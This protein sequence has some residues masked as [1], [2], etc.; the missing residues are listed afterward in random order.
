MSAGLT[1]PALSRMELYGMRLPALFGRVPKVLHTPF[2]TDGRPVYLL[3][4]PKAAGSSLKRMLHCPKGR[5]L[6]IWATGAFSRRIWRDSFVITAVRDP[7]DRFWSGYRFHVRGPYAGA[8]Y[9]RHGPALKS[10]SPED[11]FTFIQQYPEYLGPQ[12]NW[13]TYPDP[14]KP[15]ADLILRVEDS[16]TWPEKLRQAGLNIPDQDMAHENRS[17]KESAPQKLSANLLAQLCAYYA[18]DYEKLGYEF[19]AKMG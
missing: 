6:H 19:P 1:R 16:A 10:L 13:A 3:H 9:K 4:N 18:E 14:V 8:L 11:Y 12:V 15:R 5:T 17:A 2:S 7:I